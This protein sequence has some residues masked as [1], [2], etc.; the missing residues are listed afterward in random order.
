MKSYTITKKMG[1]YCLLIAGVMLWTLSAQAHTAMRFCTTWRS[2]YVDSGH[3]EDVFTSDNPLNRPAQYTRYYLRNNDTG[4]Y[5][6]S[7]YLD[8]DGCTPYLSLS[9][10]TEYKFSQGTKVSKSGAGTLYVNPDGYNWGYSYVW[11]TYYYTTGSFIYN[12]HHEHTFNPSTLNPYTNIMPIVGKVLDKYD[13]LGYNAGPYGLVTFFHTD[14][15]E[16]RNPS[17]CDHGGAYYKRGTPYICMAGDWGGSGATYWKFILGHEIGHRVADYHDGPGG[18]SYSFDDQTNP[19]CN[20]NHV[21]SGSQLHCMQSMEYIA[22]AEGEGFGH[23]FS[24]ALFNNRSSSN[25][26]F[27][28]P[29]ETWFY[30]PPYGWI[31]YPPERPFDVTNYTKWGETECSLGNENKGVELDWMEFFWHAWAD[32]ISSTTLTSSELMSVWEESSSSNYDD[33]LD[34]AFSLW[35]NTSRYV[36]FWWQGYYSGVDHHD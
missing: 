4:A 9:S 33:L 20:C 10:N 25:G 35:G 15:K 21:E 3:G 31:V 16:N 17:C 12:V 14:C 24:S 32:P 28:C 5:V 22:A 34:G 11:Y 13:T 1:T 30:F 8:S 29:K 7:G 18:G 26:I 23:F 27:V 36:Q 2:H 19:R 6:S